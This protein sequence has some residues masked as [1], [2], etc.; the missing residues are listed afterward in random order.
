MDKNSKP[1]TTCRSRLSSST[2]N[3]SSGVKDLRTILLAERHRPLPAFRSKPE[4]QDPTAQAI[5]SAVAAAVLDATEQAVYQN[6][7]SE[8]MQAAQQAAADTQALRELEDRCEAL[9]SQLASTTDSLHASETL[10]R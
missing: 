3:V 1:L 5:E 6:K 4:I 7:E 8:A 10:L 2:V 9:H